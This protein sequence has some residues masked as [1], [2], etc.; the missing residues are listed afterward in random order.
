MLNSRRSSSNCNL[1]AV[2]VIVIGGTPPAAL[3]LDLFL[4]LVV[5]PLPLYLASARAEFFLVDVALPIIAPRAVVFAMFIATD[6]A[7][8]PAFIL[9]WI[10]CGFPPIW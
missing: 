3:A 9:P 1:V 10:G 8:L 4:V 2:I 6:P 7:P 5:V